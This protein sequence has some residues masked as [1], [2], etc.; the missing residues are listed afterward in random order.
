MPTSN[1]IR[2]GAAYI[3]LYTRDSRLVKGLA[4]ASK[5]L[6]AFGAS[7]RAMGLQVV[8]AGTA[9]ITPLLASLKHFADAGD[10]LNKMSQRTGVSVEALS[11][12]GYAADQSGSD[13]TILEGSLRK[14]QK[15]L[16]QAA[17][18]S[19]PARENLKRLGL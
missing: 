2:A 13:L 14:M 3:E 9:L 16:V 11:E 8:A 19:R 15:A 7:V 18:G 10:V 17:Q 1:A 4:S 6:Q 12:L 5:R